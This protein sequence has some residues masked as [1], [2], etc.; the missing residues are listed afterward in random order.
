MNH[1]KWPQKEAQKV[2]PEQ[3]LVLPKQEQ[4]ELK[5]QNPKTGLAVHVM[6]NIARKNL[7]TPST[8]EEAG[9]NLSP[10]ANGNEERAGIVIVTAELPAQ[11][12]VE[13]VENKI[14]VPTT[15]EVLQYTS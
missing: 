3:K 14:E 10:T 9:L 6:E 4:E 11:K 8:L 5:I 13:L 15:K 12:V 2:V 1:L 7:G